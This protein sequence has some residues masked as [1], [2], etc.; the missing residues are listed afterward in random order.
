[1]QVQGWFIALKNLAERRSSFFQGT[2]N[3]I[4]FQCGAVSFAPVCGQHLQH[5]HAALRMKTA[6]SRKLAILIEAVHLSGPDA[7]RQI[8]PG[9]NAVIGIMVIDRIHL[10]FLNRMDAEIFFLPGRCFAGIDSLAADIDIGL[11]KTP[12][13]AFHE[14]FLVNHKQQMIPLFPG[15]QGK[16]AFSHI[17]IH[18]GYHPRAAW[19]ILQKDS[20]FIRILDMCLP[21][22]DRF[23][24]IHM[25][26]LIP[27]QISKRPF[28]SGIDFIQFR[29][30]PPGSFLRL[31]QPPG[32]YFRMI[33]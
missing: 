2:G 20:L 14:E 31:F 4:P 33:T 12:G 29:A 30:N 6:E 19:L 25:A 24:H 26:E 27:H 10:F 8:F 22:S 18:C 15:N 1:M 3:Q 23:N 7:L 5:S 16:K 21:P 17:H 28:F 32:F 9:M 13:D 11:S